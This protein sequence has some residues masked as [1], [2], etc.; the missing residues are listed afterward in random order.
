[1][2]VFLGTCMDAFVKFLSGRV[3]LL[4]IVF[5]RFTIAAVVIG[6]P[7]FLSGRRLTGWAPA[8]FHAVRG[9]IHVAATYLFFFALGKLDLVEVTTIGFMA[10]LIIPVIAWIYLGERINGLTFLAILIGF[11][12][13]LT[14]LNAWQIISN[15]M[16]RDRLIGFGSVLL[17][18]CL[19]AASIVLLRKRAA[20]DGALMVAF[21]AN[22]FPALFIAPFSLALATPAQPSDIGYL[23]I[24][25]VLGSSIWLLMTSAYARAP[26]QRLAPVEFTALLWSALIGLFVFREVPGA[27]LWIGAVCIIMACAIVSWQDARSAASMRA[28]AS[29]QSDPR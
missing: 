27:S 2:A 29:V 13:V 11:A 4:T 5:W 15:E 1:M 10:S 12:G 20:A 28:R 6:V 26:A 17:S 22:L 24:A 8:R 14:A 25:A 9:V 23:I 16:S 21:Y 7:F 18:A 3:D 19:Y